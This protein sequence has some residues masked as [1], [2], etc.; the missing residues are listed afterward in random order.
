MNH[1]R[2][3]KAYNPDEH[4]Q[5]LFSQIDDVQEIG[6]A[7]NAPYSNEQLVQAGEISIVN[8]GKYI[9]P[10]TEWISKRVTDKTWP[11]FKTD[12]LE[13]CMIRKTVTTNPL[14]GRVFFRK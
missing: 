7:A 1:A 13:A 14:T 6:I 8:T 9:I 4:I 2:M 11:N 3:T 12:F 5:V 10:Y